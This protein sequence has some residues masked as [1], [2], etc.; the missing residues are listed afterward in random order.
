MA[1]PETE[2]RQSLRLPG[3]VKGIHL[4]YERYFPEY[5]QRMQDMEQQRQ[6]QQAQ[7]VAQDK[8]TQGTD[9]NHD[10]GDRTDASDP[11]GRFQRGKGELNEPAP[12]AG[13]NPDEWYP[14]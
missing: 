2:G 14:G 13:A 8:A 5:R 6:Q 3:K 9:G 11:I 12:I 7:A 4:Q 10:S 1:L